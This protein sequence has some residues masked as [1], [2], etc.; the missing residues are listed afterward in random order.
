[1]MEPFEAGTFEL[2]E[3]LGDDAAAR[4]KSGAESLRQ[5]HDEA[6]R[7]QV[8]GAKGLGVFDQ[9]VEIESDRGVVGGDHR[10]RAHTDEHVDRDAAAQQL[11]QHTDMSGAAKAARAEHDADTDR[12]R[13]ALPPSQSQMVPNTNP[14]ARN[15]GMRRAVAS[16]V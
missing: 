14:L 8:M 7:E 9:R 3:P 1:V 10:A 4:L 11:P 13:H 5:A 16:T 6:V 12:F 2:V 15:S